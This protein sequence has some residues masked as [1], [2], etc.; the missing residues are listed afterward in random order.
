[1]SVSSRTRSAGANTPCTKTIISARKCDNIFVGLDALLAE[2]GYRRRGIIY[3]VDEGCNTD[4]NIAIFCHMGLGTLLIVAVCRR[5]AA[6]RVADV[7]RHAHLCFDCGIRRHVA[8][9][10]TDENL[11]DR[12]HDASPIHRPD[13]QGLNFAARQNRAII[14]GEKLPAACYTYTAAK[15][16]RDD[17]ELG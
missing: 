6:A 3:E 1:M 17:V 12:R 4:A 13:L 11:R 9:L 8:G 16:R 7:P 10:G 15:G 5:H 2:N 14:I